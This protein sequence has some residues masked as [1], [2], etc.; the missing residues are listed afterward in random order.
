MNKSIG[1]LIGL[2]FIIIAIIA[3][4]IIWEVLSTRW[5]ELKREAARANRL[6]QAISNSRKMREFE[7]NQRRELDR[8]QSQYRKELKRLE[9]RIN[10]K[11]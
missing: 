8:I 5:K 9:R 4:F 10:K 6:E 1:I 11:P 7:R 2:P 3:E